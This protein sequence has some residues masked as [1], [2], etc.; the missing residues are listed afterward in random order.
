M[1]TR[2]ARGA[3]V[4]QNPDAPVP[5]EVLATSLVRIAEAFQKLRASGLN[6]RA[7]VILV[8]ASSGQGRGVVE[9]VLNALESLR[10]DYC[11]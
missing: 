4:V 3:T 10:K 6:R 7:I 1:A 5:R 11:S 9:H 8:S 2:A